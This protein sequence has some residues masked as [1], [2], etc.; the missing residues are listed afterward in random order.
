M[1]L[2]LPARM[3]YVQ[4]ADAVTYTATHNGMGLCA[5]QSDERVLFMNELEGA[6]IKFQ[7]YETVVLIGSPTSYVFQLNCR[8]T[9]GNPAFDSKC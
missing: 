6:S 8:E 7:G 4:L 9:E 2:L 3:S 1:K 5:S